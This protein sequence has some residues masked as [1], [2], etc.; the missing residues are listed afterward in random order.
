M[1]ETRY[2]IKT[3][4]TE[5]G[6]EIESI[7]TN[8]DFMRLLSHTRQSRQSIQSTTTSINKFPPIAREITLTK[9]DINTLKDII[10]K[11]NAIELIYIYVNNYNIDDKPILDKYYLT[12]TKLNSLQDTVYYHQRDDTIKAEKISPK[13]SIKN[14]NNQYHPSGN[15]I[16]NENNDNRLYYSN[17]KECLYLFT[18]KIQEYSSPENKNYLIETYK[19]KYDFTEDEAANEFLEKL[20]LKYLRILALYIF[21]S[22]FKLDI[23]L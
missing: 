8:N 19:E 16:I 9:I 20:S 10:L 23:N 13:Y 7:I 2:I 1:E 18:D 11:N 6:E 22:G 3:K 5:Y 4:M 12:I 15:E 21:Q 14:D 17:S